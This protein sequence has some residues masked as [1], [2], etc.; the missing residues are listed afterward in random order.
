MAERTGGPSVNKGGSHQSKDAPA[1]IC[2]GAKNKT[3]HLSSGPTGAA[4]V[5]NK[6]SNPYGPGSAAGKSGK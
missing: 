5:G 4:R 2:V 3:S 6:A 1:T